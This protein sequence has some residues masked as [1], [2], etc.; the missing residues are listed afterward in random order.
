MGTDTVHD[1]RL[2]PDRRQDHY[3]VNAEREARRRGLFDIP[4][5]DCDSH[6]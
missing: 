3:L 1:G 6:C 4:I 5:V 2:L